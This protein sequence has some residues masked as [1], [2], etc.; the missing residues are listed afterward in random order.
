MKCLRC[1]R[2]YTH[3]SIEDTTPR[4]DLSLKE[5]DTISDHFKNISFCGQYSDPTHHPEFIEI[6]KNC[7][8]KKVITSVDVA[9]AVR[10]ERWFIEA[11]QA[12]PEALWIFGIDG[13]P[14][15]SHKYR[16]NQNG[17]KLFNLMV[18]SKKYLA[19]K[20][21][22]QYIVFNYNEDHVEEALNMARLRAVE[23]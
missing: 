2:N 7:Y 3:W 11:F 12:N 19:K 14:E 17:V 6:L 4:Y 9:S 15:E 5:F 8:S 22:W 1:A 13:L 20:P 18:E 21:R 10:P 16:V 23:P